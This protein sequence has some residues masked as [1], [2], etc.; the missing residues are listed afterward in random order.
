VVHGGGGIVPDVVLQDTS[1]S[2]L[3]SDVVR[4]GLL[5]RFAT[6]VVA[7][8]TGLP[9]AAADVARFEDSVRAVAGKADM[10]TWAEDRTRLVGLLSA[11]V[12]RRVK[13]EQEGQRQALQTDRAFQ[14]ALR[15]LQR[16][17][18]SRELLQLASTAAKPAAGAKGV[19]GGQSPQ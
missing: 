5:F 4:D 13:G 3:M 2:K 17:H 7:A 11:E 16:A 8:R 19:A 9:L 6:H 14:A 12:T 15:L 10:A 18:T 1:F